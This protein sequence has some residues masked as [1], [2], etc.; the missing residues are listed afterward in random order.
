MS[1]ETY[2][3]DNR[4]EGNRLQQGDNH[5]QQGGNHLQQG[6]NHHL[7]LEQDI[8]PLQGEGNL[9]LQGSQHPQEETLAVED[10]L[11]QADQ[12]VGNQMLAGNLRHQVGPHILVAVRGKSLK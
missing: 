2:L 9:R 4:Q 3:V 8:L 11:H 7:Q 5:L 6:D 1:C 10:S 12:L